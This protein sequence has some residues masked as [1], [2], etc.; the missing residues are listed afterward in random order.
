MAATVAD[1]AVGCTWLP[2][3]LSTTCGPTERPVGQGFCTPERLVL[4]T[5][6]TGKRVSAYW[7]PA[8]HVHMWT[9]PHGA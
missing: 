5:W 2:S 7:T 4:N 1:E 8:Q 6:R 9:R 3:G